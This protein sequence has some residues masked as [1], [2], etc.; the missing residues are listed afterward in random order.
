MTVAFV[1]PCRHAPIPMMPRPTLRGAALLLAAATSSGCFVPEGRHT[2]RFRLVDEPVGAVVSDTHSYF[3]WG[4]VPT[5]DVDVLEKCPYGAVAVVD[6]TPGLHAWVPT[7]G[8][9]SRRST[10]YYCR[11]PPAP[12]AER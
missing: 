11:Q 4:L 7:L 12:E 6:G 5:V 8:L 9:W 3:L 1:A 2:M 10:M